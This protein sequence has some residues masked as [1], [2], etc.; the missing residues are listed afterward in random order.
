MTEESRTVWIRTTPDLDGIYLVVL[1]IDDDTSHPLDADT[2]MAYARAVLCAV[3]R[4]EHDAA[5]VSQMRKIGEG[6]REGLQ[7]AA[8]LVGSIRGD[9]PPISWPTPLELAP[10]VST[11]TGAPFLT[12][13]IK[14]TAVGQWTMEDARGHALGVLEAV[15]AADLDAAYLRAL[16]G[17]EIDEQRARAIVADLANHR[18][19]STE[20]TGQ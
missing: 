6:G 19:D 4:A 7:A 11:A 2:A 18:T 3:A 14:V 17:L 5:V 9:R 15:E 10:V 1:E 16:R 8:E 20:E 12:V 13:S